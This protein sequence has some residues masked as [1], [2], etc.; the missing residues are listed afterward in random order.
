LEVTEDD[1]FNDSEVNTHTVIL[2]DRHQVD[3]DKKKKI[4]AIKE[5]LM[6][7]RVPFIA[8]LMLSPLKLYKEFGIFPW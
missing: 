4:N 3:E 8:S 2:M 5:K 7:K 1:I 6:D